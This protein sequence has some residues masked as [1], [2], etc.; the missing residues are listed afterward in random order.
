M[1]G[2]SGPVQPVGCGTEVSQREGM[3]GDP[4]DLWDRVRRW[5]ENHPQTR[6]HIS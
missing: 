4:Q 6:L 1:G 5:E 3:V 2:G